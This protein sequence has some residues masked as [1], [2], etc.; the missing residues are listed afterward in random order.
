VPRLADAGQ[1]LASESTMY[2]VLREEQQLAHRGRTAVPQRRAAPSHDATG[3]NQVW[4]WDITYLKSPVR[5]VFWYLYLILDIWSRKIVGWTVATTEQSAH[6]ATLFRAT[7]AAVTTDPN[8]I[9]LHADN[10]GPMKGATMLATLERLGVIAAFSRPGVSND[11]PFSEALFRTAKYR[12]DFPREPFT[13]VASA[14]A[15][16]AAFVQWYNSIARFAL[17]RRPSATTGVK[18]PSLP[19]GPQSMPKRKLG[20]R[21][22][23]VARHATG[24]PS[25]PCDSIRPTRSPPRTT[26][27]SSS[28]DNCLDTHRERQPR[29]GLGPV[30]HQR[31][32][33]RAVRA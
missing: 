17:S 33:P 32:V 4:S 9:V 25:P 3:P 2:R 11:N 1:Y 28:Y 19:S 18:M 10:G 23:G 7:C 5:G 21:R 14:A 22:G 30:P 27:S 15:W 24:H 8:G 26:A 29:H 31:P 12:P 13:D 16:V 20:I 6:A